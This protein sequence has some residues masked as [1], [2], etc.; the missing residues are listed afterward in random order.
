MKPELGEQLY[1][2]SHIPGAAFAHL[3]RDL[4]AR[5]TGKNGRHPLPDPNTFAAWLGA[6]G[7]KRHSIVLPRDAVEAQVVKPE[8][9]RADP[10]VAKHHSASAILQ[11]KRTG[12]QLIIV[13]V[14]GRLS[15]QFH[16]EMRTVR[17]NLVM[18]PAIARLEH[19]LRFRNVHD[20]ARAVRGV[21]PLIENI[22]LVASRR[23]D[24]ARIG[25]ADEHAAIGVRRDPK[26]EVEVEIRI[27]RRGQQKARAGIGGD[28]TFGELP[29]G[30]AD[31]SPAG[32]AAAVE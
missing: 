9:I 26:L 22:D 24:L 14:Y 16:D 10:H 28:G 18:V 12:R 19:D 31:L 7:L 2:E 17:R 15:V 29:V 21:G 8:L 30:V 23:T 27:R 5:K 25:A 1:R 11:S 13:S 32:E 20:A 4:S 3:E 6:Q